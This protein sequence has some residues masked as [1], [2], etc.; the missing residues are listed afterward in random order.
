M[1]QMRTAWQLQMMPVEMGFESW[2][3][4]GKLLHMFLFCYYMNR[5]LHSHQVP[6]PDHSLRQEKNE[7][8]G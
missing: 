8:A 1:S 4:T 3:K 7:E 5:T 2:W 6:L